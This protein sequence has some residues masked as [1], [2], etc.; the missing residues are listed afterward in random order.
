ME[1]MTIDWDKASEGGDFQVYPTGTYKVSVN[2]YE[3]VTASTGTKQI[4]WKT[5]IMEPKEYIGKP[6]TTH[7]PLT[8][9]SL[10]KL[11]KL[12]KACSIDVKSLG[13]MVIP[14]PAFY[15]VL[16]SCKRRTAYWHLVKDV[17]N[18]GKDVNEVDDFKIDN[19]QVAEAIDNIIVDD[20]PPFLKEEV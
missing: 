6:F 5:T 15:K 12:V 19:D 4:R 11:A 2:N 17:N 16:E 7:T 9:A 3:E 10:W 18:K 1:K 20:V 14:S 13:T 8:P